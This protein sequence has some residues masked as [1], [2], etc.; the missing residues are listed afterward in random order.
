MQGLVYAGSIIIMLWGIAHLVPTGAI[1]KGFG[2]ITEDNKKILAMEVISEGVTLIFLGLFPLLTT[3]I[4]GPDEKASHL[5]LFGFA[6]MLILMAIL[7]A[8]TGARTPT[9]WYKLCPGVKTLAAV[10]FILGAVL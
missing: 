5:V 1:I 2:K 3:L 10:L 6:G 7:T 4:L 9:I 8:L